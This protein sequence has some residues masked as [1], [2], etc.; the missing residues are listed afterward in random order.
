MPDIRY[1]DDREALVQPCSY[2]KKDVEF[3]N[4]GGGSHPESEDFETRCNE[5]GAV[6]WE[7]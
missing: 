2:C 3:H 6:L 1:D 7:S 5:C 4:Q